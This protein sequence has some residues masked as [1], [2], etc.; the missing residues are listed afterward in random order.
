MNGQITAT[1]VFILSLYYVYTSNKYIFVGFFLHIIPK[2]I[3]FSSRLDKLLE[4][5]PEE[6]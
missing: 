4:Q 3:H 5:H 1:F 2:Q 6:W